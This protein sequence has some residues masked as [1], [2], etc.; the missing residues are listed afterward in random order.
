[1]KTKASCRNCTCEVIDPKTDQVTQVPDC[2]CEVR[3]KC[4]DDASSNEKRKQVYA[5]WPIIQEELLL[6]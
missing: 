2:K 5:E 6:N 3:D 4:P 1:M